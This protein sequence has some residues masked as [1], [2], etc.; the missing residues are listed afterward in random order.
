MNIFIQKLGNRLSVA[1][2]GFFIIG[3]LA[4]CSSNR[5]TSSANSPVSSTVNS[6]AESATGQTQTP[7]PEKEKLRKER[8]KLE[9][10]KQKLKEEKAK[11]EKMKNAVAPGVDD[12]MIGEALVYAPPSHIRDVPDGKILCTVSKE[13][14]IKLHG[15][16]RIR[17]KNGVWIYTDHCGKM[18]VIHSSQV[19]VAG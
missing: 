14:L 12:E 13:M 2:L 9:Q 10:D 8:E 6:P 19:S 3:G 18:G 5:T 17:D 4:A 7:D 11:L 16:T 1:A 15:S